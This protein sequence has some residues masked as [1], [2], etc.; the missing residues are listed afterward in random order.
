MH[1]VCDGRAGPGGRDGA[2]GH[3]CPRA[4]SCSGPRTRSPRIAATCS[5][6]CTAPAS[7]CSSAAATN[8][9]D[10]L[11]AGAELARR[12]AQVTAILLQ[13]D[14]AH[15]GGL[16][17]LRRAG[18]RVQDAA[19][20]EST[21][22]RADLV[23]DGILGIG[24]KG[25]LRGAAA[26]LAAV[27]A[28]RLTVAVDLPSGVDADT[29]A[30]GEHAIRA[31]VTVTFGAL[32]PGLVSGAG[33]RTGG[34][35]A[36]RRHRAGDNAARNDD[37]TCSRRATSRGLLPQPTAADDKYTRGV[38]GVVAGSPQ[39]PGAGRAV[40]RI[41]A[42]RRRRHGA[43][44]RA[45]ARTRSAPATRRWWRIQT[46]GRTKFRCRPGRS[47][48]AWGPTTP[49][50]RCSRTRW[51][52]TS[53]PSSTLTRSRSSRDHPAWCATG[54]AADRAHAARPRVRADGRRGD[55]GP[56]RIR[57]TGSRRPRRDRAAQ[58]QRHRGRRPRRSG[59]REPDRNAMARH[60]RQRRRAERADRVTARRR[61]GAGAAA[62]VG[63]YVHGVAGQLAGASGPPTAADVLHALRP[64]L[65][66]IERHLAA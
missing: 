52:P 58:G 6:R 57:P 44:P 19:D 29:G 3:G 23:I 16:A 48:R 43:L 63:A 60:R 61:S 55:R 10:A 30:V 13:P 35:G 25:G 54:A 11:Y 37:R 7:C 27:A 12:G 51:A 21:I 41:G 34:R 45:G 56:D 4:R 42:V 17:A 64:A 53:R 62:A 59:L 32:K 9:G 39:Y 5:D 15:P 24:G 1:G 2:D 31:D 47:G 33:A 22:E 40:H 46:P 65:H 28:D 50:W 8:G 26:K 20:A 18:G 14:R 36:A 38:A 66:R 49:R